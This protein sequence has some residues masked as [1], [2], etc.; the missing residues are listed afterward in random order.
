MSI[1]IRII[2]MTWQYN[3]RLVLS[4]FTFGLSIGFALAIPWMLGASIDA[5]VTTEGGRII[6]AVNLA[7]VR[8]D[9]VGIFET[10]LWGAAGILLAASLLRGFF[11]FAR[12]YTSDSLAQKVAYDLRNL[13]YDKLQ[14]LS[15]AFHDKEH[16]GNLYSKATADVEAIRRFVMMGMVRS[17]EVAAR[18]AAIS[19]I[20]AFIHRQLALLSLIFLPF[21]VGRST[22]VLL[23]LRVMWLHAQEVM[24][25]LVTVLQENLSGIHVVKA[26]ASEEYEKKKYDA[27]ARELRVE[28]Y[29]NERTMG[30]NSA[31]ITLYFTL[32]LGFIMWFGGLQVINENLTA[33]ELTKFVLYMGQLVFP[34]RMSA[35]VIATFSRA[36][37]SG[38]RIYDVLDARSP[39]EEK[40][41]ARD[42]GRS[43]GHVR[44][45]NVSFSYDRDTPAL[46]NVDID[47]PP[48]AV[49]ALLGAPGSGKSTIVNLLPRFYA[50]TGGRI[51]IDGI[52]IQDFTLASLRRNVG[53]VQQDVYLFSATVKDTHCLRRF[54]CFFGKC[55]P[56]SQGRP[57]S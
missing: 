4:Y 11:D 37:S 13:M 45:E 25:E 12:T 18:V 56:G 31:W 39:V 23:K 52:D 9:V 47:V 44:F 36:I 41:E 24:G 7:D 48:G 22:S 10:S 27:K 40:P 46:Q 34:I 42:M 8:V 30:T 16:T 51:T 50:V 57:A 21:L 5:L 17:I 32:A 28:Y 53:I 49:V 43:E 38:E 26:F 6:P 2:M 29:E 35:F 20:L 1:L 3:I 54:R 33:G 15:F 19:I 55:R 14:H